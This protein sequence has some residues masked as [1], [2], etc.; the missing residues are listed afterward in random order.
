M[1]HEDDATRGLT[2]RELLL[3]L[4]ADVKE[5][6]DS[7]SKKP[8]RKEVWATIIGVATVMSIAAGL[9]S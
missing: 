3:E 9:L 8:D 4:R 2:L 5:L 1:P 7:N 6:V